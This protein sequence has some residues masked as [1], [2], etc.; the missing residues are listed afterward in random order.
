M[1]VSSPTASDPDSTGPAPSGVRVPIR[2]CI[3]CRMRVVAAELLRVVAVPGPAVV[4]DPRHRAPGRGAWVHRDLTCVDL[5]ERRRAFG[6]AFRV[7]GPVDPS[8]LREYVTQ[9]G[10]PSEVA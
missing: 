5:A 9:L 3:G 7:P 8:A 4:P 6:R 10:A 1:A 2:T